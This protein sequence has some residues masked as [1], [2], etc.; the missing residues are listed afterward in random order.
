MYSLSLWNIGGAGST[1]QYPKPLRRNLQ[2]FRNVNL[3]VVCPHWADSVEELGTTDDEIVAG[4]SSRVIFSG[5]WSGRS[6]IGL[7]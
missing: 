5:S 6:P 4:E 3:W 2:V 1:I 7:V